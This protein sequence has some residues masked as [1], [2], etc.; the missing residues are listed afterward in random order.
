MLWSVRTVVSVMVLASGFGGRIA[1]IADEPQPAVQY[2][3]A[4]EAFRVGAAFLS[5]RQYAKSQA[6]LEAALKLAKDDEFRLKTY[7]ALI[8][9]YTQAEDWQLKAG[10]LE[11]IIEKTNRDAEQSLARTELMGFL[12][13]RGKAEAALKRY[14]ERLQETPDHEAT[15]FI[16]IEVYAR[17]KDDPQRAAATL[18]R[19]AALR[20]KSGEEL[21]VT[22]AAKLAGEYVRARK[23]QEGAELFEK[24][25]AR[26]ASLAAWHFKEAAAAWLKAGNKERARAAAKAS[27]A[28]TPEKRSELLQHFWHR[29]LADAFFDVGD[30][31]DAIPHYEQAIARTTIDG[32]RKD[33]EK[34]LEEARRLAEQ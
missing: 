29:G 27:T 24:T 13:E 14:E 22:E 31:A 32:Y 9:A 3:T 23:Y 10:A 16:L 1:A 26:D 34:R 18:E 33:C 15:L 21:R 25:A 5:V 17:L 19:L 7:R 20:Q 4:E 12:R 2:D 30:Y 8:P 6:P 28:A 11:F